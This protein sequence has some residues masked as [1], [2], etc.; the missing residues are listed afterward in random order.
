MA[1]EKLFRI[2]CYLKT[3]RLFSNSREQTGVGVGGAGG[4]GWGGAAAHFI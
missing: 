1:T 4:G 3:M 2:I